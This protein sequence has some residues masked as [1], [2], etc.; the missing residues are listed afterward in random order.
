M[1]FTFFKKNALVSQDFF[2]QE[3]WNHLHFIS[4]HKLYLC[5]IS[6]KALFKSSVSGVPLSP[7]TPDM[8]WSAG[9][10]QRTRH[11]RAQ[12]YRRFQKGERLIRWCLQESTSRF[13]RLLLSH[14]ERSQE[15]CP[16]L[17][18][19]NAATYV[20]CFRPFEVESWKVFIGAAQRGSSVSHSHPNSRLSKEKQMF[21]AAGARN[22]LVSIGTNHLSRCWPRASP[23]D[24]WRSGLY[25]HSYLWNIPAVSPVEGEPLPTPGEPAVL[26]GK[27]QTSTCKALA[28]CS[29]PAPDP[30]VAFPSSLFKG[31]AAGR[32]RPVVHVSRTWELL[33]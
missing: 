7:P 11:S 4:C 17:P 24:A 27:L 33:Q 22:N 12:G 10:A 32:W 2:P 30:D 28:E 26:L 16:V 3:N 1:Y 20:Q 6:R 5:R 13:S 21:S 15:P 19:G 29:S 14:Q 31:G 9:R 25:V 18:Q 23:A 8:W